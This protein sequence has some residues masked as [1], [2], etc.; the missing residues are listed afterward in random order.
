M[1]ICIR[2][3]TLYCI[4]TCLLS[5]QLCQTLRRESVYF[6]AQVTLRQLTATASSSSHHKLPRL[7]LPADLRPSAVLDLS[8]EDSN[9]I[10]NVMRLRDGEAFRVFNEREGEFLAQV[11]LASRQQRRSSVTVR[12]T[13]GDQIRPIDT[14]QESGKVSLDLLF[15]PIKKDRVK[16]LVEKATELGVDR[17]QPVL[18]QNTNYDLEGSSTMETLRKVIIQS[19]EQSERLTVP[20]LLPPLTLQEVLSLGSDGHGPILACTE[21][22]RDQPSL[23]SALLDGSE[24]VERVRLLVGPEGGF[25]TEEMVQLQAAGPAVRCVSLGE[26][27]LRAETAAIC[28]LSIAR[29]V[30][31]KAMASSSY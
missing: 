9:Y 2:L 22:R 31:D 29:A 7:Y 24:Q 27:I 25:T 6:P 30:V 28:G 20:E 4:M 16:L 14:K 15:A 18:T 13:V 12:A 11:S 3:A 1:H 19:V 17:L 26:N 10:K 8:E 21:R 23:L 5:L